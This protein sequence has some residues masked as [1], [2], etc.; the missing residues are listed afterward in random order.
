MAVRPLL[1]AWLLLMALTAVAGFVAN[2]G[3]HEAP[4]FLAMVALGVVVV[5]KSRTILVRYLR[6]DLKPAFLTAFTAA[7]VVIVSIAVL[8]LVVQIPAIKLPKA[9]A[10]PA[11][12]QGDDRAAAAPR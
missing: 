4:G 7:V 10:V 5:A 8:A 2:A 11:I 12:P 3:G 1:L 6:L 9:G